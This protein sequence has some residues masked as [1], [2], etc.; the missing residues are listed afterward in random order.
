MEGREKGLE[1]IGGFI[2]F[3]LARPLY[4]SKRPA[5]ISRRLITYGRGTNPE[6]HARPVVEVGPVF[7][8]LP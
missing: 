1:A 6:V 8:K 7:G 5:E 2:A 3:L 4:G